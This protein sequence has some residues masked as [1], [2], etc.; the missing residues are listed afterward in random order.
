MEIKD[1]E[2]LRQFEVK[3]DEGLLTIEYSLQERKIF[4][5]KFCPNDCEDEK[6]HQEFIK[7]VLDL[8]EERNLRVVP[9]HAKLISFFRKNR[10]YQN[11]L[12]P[13]IKI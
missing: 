1:N 9:T 8:V 2:L 13:G 6:V 5:T 10:R 3:T 7:T 11:M 4:L 12:P